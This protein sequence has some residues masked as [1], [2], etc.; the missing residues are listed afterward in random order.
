MT[1]DLT[2]R[3]EAYEEAV[4]HA[5][6]DRDLNAQTRPAR[7]RMSRGI[8]RLTDR[9]RELARHWW[10]L[11]KKTWDGFWENHVT[12]Q[13]P[14]SI[15]ALRG[16]IHSAAWVPGEMPVLEVLGRLYGYGIALPVSAALYTLAWLLQ[17][18]GRALLTA[19][20]AAIVWFTAT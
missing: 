5:A 18:P 14:A 3:D 20:V 13:H 11:A 7:T 16:Y 17:R 9:S 1:S 2:T 10:D 19:V 12:E 6:P 8:A 15:A 4:P